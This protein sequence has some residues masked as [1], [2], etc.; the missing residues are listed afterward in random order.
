MWNSMRKY[1][2]HYCWLISES[3][4]GPA[5]LNNKLRVLQYIIYIARLGYL[6]FRNFSAFYR[7]RYTVQQVLIR[8][9]RFRPCMGH[10][11]FFI[12]WSYSCRIRQN[13]IVSWRHFRSV[14]HR[15]LYLWNT[16]HGKATVYLYFQYKD[17]EVSINNKQTK[18]A[19][20]KTVNK[21]H[22]RICLTR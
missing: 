18:T 22:F 16:G 11:L 4:G 17:N 5:E 19:S 14:L 21:V 7:L 15:E 3:T 12:Q 6:Y 1:I 20:C 10:T 2:V 13:V 8:F 9:Y